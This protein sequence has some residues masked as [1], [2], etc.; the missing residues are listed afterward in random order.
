[1]HAKTVLKNTCPGSVPPRPPRRGGGGLSVVLGL[2]S[3][4][5]ML[6]R[7]QRWFRARCA[8]PVVER[9]SL[10]R[11]ANARSAPAVVFD[12]LVGGEAHSLMKRQ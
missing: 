12:S 4:R 8:H 3:G 2:G 1:M 7:C 5:V 10:L 6:S 9:G 11:G